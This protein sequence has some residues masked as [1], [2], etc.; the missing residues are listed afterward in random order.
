MCEP[1]GSVGLVPKQPRSI[2][3][4]GYSPGRSLSH[5]ARSSAHCKSWLAAPAIDSRAALGNAS[6]LKSLSR[7]DLG[8]Q[9][10]CLHECPKRRE[11]G[12]PVS[13]HLSQWVNFSIGSRYA[14]LKS[15]LSEYAIGII[16]ACI[17]CA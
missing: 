15:F 1:L 12:P 2:S 5:P 11:S 13:Y 4:L 9:P 3:L 7:A 16:A 10:G 6:H 8:Q 17:T 14:G